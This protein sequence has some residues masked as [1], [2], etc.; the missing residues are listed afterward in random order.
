MWDYGSQNLHIGCWTTD[1]T[2]GNIRVFV[3]G[4]FDIFDIIICIE[5]RDSKYTMLNAVMI[6]YKFFY[7]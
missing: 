5:I 2:L 6:Y 3:I 4:F 1:S 7:Y